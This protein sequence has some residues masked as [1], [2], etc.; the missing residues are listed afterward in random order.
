VARIKVPREADGQ[1][2]LDL[3]AG[4]FTYHTR[5]EWQARVAAGRVTVEGVTVAAD[6]RLRGGTTLEYRV[7]DLPEPPVCLDC[8]ILYSDP[9]LLVI[10]KPGNLPCHPAG[11]FFRHTLWGV[12]RERFPE[13]RLHFVNRLDR[14]TSG[15]VLLAANPEACRRCA[16]QFA[17]GTVS[18]RYLAVVEGAFP[19]AVEAAGWLS[20]DRASAV[21]K[22]W[23]FSHAAPDAPEARRAH[24]L[25]RRQSTHGPLSLVAAELKTGKAHQIRATLLALGFPIVGDKLYGVDETL[26]LR[27]CKGELTNEDR[28]RLRMSRQALHASGL[29][30]RHPKFGRLVTV[31]LD[32]PDDMQQLLGT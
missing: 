4:R 3:L 18:K 17:A 8:E 7:P 32:L 16:R 24:T 23:R 9:D 28:V 29:S 1:P 5:A 26:F 27:F 10:N 19:E 30:F 12:L 25:F 21:R 22:K 14:E 6:T 31:D 13:W 15:L 2:L 20:W 11:R